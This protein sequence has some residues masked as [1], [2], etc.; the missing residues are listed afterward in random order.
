MESKL[1]GSNQRSGNLTA[2]SAAVGGDAT[3]ADSGDG[4]AEGT[5]PAQ[6]LIALRLAEYPGLVKPDR[7]VVCYSS[8]PVWVGCHVGAYEQ[9]K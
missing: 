7:A 5:C 3:G 2:Q 8:L 6:S 4:P 9:A 1:T